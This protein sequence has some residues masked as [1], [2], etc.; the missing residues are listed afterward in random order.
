[1]SVHRVTFEVEVVISTTPEGEAGID[2]FVG[3]PAGNDLQTTPGLTKQ[4]VLAVLGKQCLYGRTDA[5]QDGWADLDR[6][7]IQMRIDEIR[8]SA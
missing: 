5:N 3:L 8:E 7:S 6:D 1:M 4:D 2:R